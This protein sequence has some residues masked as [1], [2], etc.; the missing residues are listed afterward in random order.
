MMVIPRQKANKIK[1]IMNSFSNG[2]ISLIKQFINNHGNN[3]FD[4]VPSM[5][6]GNYN[7]MIFY[8]IKNGHFDAFKLYLSTPNPTPFS[9][10]ELS[11]IARHNSHKRRFRNWMDNY[12]ENSDIQSFMKIE[13]ILPYFVSNIISTYDYDLI[14]E[15][16]EMYPEKI[17]SIIEAIGTSAKGLQLKRHLKLKAIL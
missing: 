16:L 3:I 15:L 10:S 14:D 4:Y 2:D 17:T 9:R 13:D 12:F 7:R 6:N 11:L 8:T 1:L 5:K